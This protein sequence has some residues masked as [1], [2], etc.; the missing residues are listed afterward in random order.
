MDGLF[1]VSAF[2]FIIYV[3]FVRIILTCV[4]IML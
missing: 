3:D 1:L 4:G 2:F